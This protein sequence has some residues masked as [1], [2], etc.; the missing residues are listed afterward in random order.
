MAQKHL[1][2]A[3]VLSPRHVGGYMNATPADLRYLARR[4]SVC[5]LLHYGSRA[6]CGNTEGWVQ[7]SPRGPNRQDPQSIDPV[8][9]AFEM[10]IGR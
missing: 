9:Q 2:A 8:S 10:R 7:F 3:C 5:F 1:Q 4:G 6:G